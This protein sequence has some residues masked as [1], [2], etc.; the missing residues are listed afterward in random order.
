LVHDIG[1]LSPLDVKGMLDAE[2]RYSALNA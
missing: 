1:E 2:A